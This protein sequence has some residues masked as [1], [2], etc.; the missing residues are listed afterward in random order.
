MGFLYPIIQTFA[1]VVA[2]IFFKDITI[3]GQE[4]IPQTGPVIF[5]GT[6]ANQF[7]DAMLMV[8]SAQRKVGFIIA[9]KSYRR[10]LIGF[11]SKGLNS[12]PV[13]RPQDLAKAGKGAIIEITETHIRGKNTKFTEEIKPGDVLKIKDVIAEL[14]VKQV[15]SDTELTYD[16]DQIV[17]KSGIESGYK[18]IPKIDQS[19][20]YES[21]WQRLRSGGTVGIFPEG[22][23]HDQTQML[24]LKAGVCIMALGAMLDNDTTPVKI[25]PCGLNYY[26]ANRFRSKAVVEFGIPYEVPRKLV[27]TYKKSKKEAISKLLSEIEQRMRAVR[28]SAPTY[29]ELTSLYLIRKL[30]TPA[31]ANLTP[32]EEY[33]FNQILT[34]GYSELKDEPRVKDFLIKVNQYNKDLRRLRLD[35]STVKRISSQKLKNIISFFYS[36]MM[37]II[38]A[39]FAA[40]GFLLNGPLGLLIKYL[41]EKERKKV[42]E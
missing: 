29:S 38:S 26:R 22:G 16:A 33:L 7:L 5:C 18:I 34:Q 24:P 17:V 13:E 3:V 37:F 41:S 27:E 6:H 30:Y 40:P 35:D 42:L 21:V 8:M 11:F 39:I 25:V 4:N 1:S 15:N 2:D 20:M 14:R 32:E 19:T 9:A 36:L 23:S 28:I 31:K 10:P 12:I